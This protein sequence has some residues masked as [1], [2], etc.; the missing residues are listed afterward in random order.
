MQSSARDSAGLP[1]RQAGTAS[2]FEVIIVS[3][4]LK[5]CQLRPTSNLT[6][7]NHQCHARLLTGQRMQMIAKKKRERMSRMLVSKLG[8][9]TIL[10]ACSWAVIAS[11]IGGV[12]VSFP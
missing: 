1:Q 12:Y 5:I 2:P 3:L 7:C 8:A 9:V 6:L 11:V 10:A 4:E